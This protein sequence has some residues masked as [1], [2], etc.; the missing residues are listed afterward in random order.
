MSPDICEKKVKRSLAALVILNGVDLV[1]TMSLFE[2]RYIS[3]GNPL[4]A[5][6][7]SC[8]ALTFSVLKLILCYVGVLIIYRHRALKASLYSAYFVL[9]VYCGIMAKHCWVIASLLLES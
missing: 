9:V 5:L 7:L 1:L 4:M 6:L 3:E 2:G 8:N